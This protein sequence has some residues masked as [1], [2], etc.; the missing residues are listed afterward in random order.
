MIPRRSV[1]TLKIADRGSLLILKLKVRQL[2][3]VQD[4]YIL[5]GFYNSF[6]NRG[7]VPLALLKVANAQDNLVKLFICAIKSS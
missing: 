3:N 4:Y 1:A 6:F 2:F 7:A 5:K